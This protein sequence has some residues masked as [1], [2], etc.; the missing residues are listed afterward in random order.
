M[1]NLHNCPTRNEALIFTLLLKHVDKRAIQGTIY[2]LKWVL[3]ALM[4]AIFS[5]RFLKHLSGFL[6]F[7]CAGLLSML[8][9]QN[10]R[11]YI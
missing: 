5:D 8:S 2:I 6:V 1:D 3:L 9:S 10:I 4:M 7:I 11:S